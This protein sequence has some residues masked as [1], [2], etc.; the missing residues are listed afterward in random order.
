MMVKSSGCIVVV[1]CIVGRWI[2]RLGM[3]V[4]MELV[5]CGMLCGYDCVVMCEVF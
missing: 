2:I 3:W 4:V 5:V 1:C